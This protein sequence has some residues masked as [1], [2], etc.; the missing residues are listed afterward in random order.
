MNLVQ[1]GYDNGDNQLWDIVVSKEKYD[2]WINNCIKNKSGTSWIYLEGER[3]KV[4]FTGDAL[5]CNAVSSEPNA[6]HFL[7][8]CE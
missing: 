5:Y 8:K 2:S 1:M 7:E 6:W 3:R 4:Y